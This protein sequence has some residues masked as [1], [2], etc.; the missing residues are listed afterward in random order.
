MFIYVKMTLSPRKSNRVSHFD[1]RKNI[2]GVNESFTILH[3]KWQS[4]GDEAIKHP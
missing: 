4:S 3:N 2:S 1:L